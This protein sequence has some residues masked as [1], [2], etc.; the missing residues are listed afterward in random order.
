MTQRS[1]TRMRYT[2]LVLLLIGV[3]ELIAEYQS[4]EPVALHYTI[5]TIVLI[6][7]FAVAL[8]RLRDVTP[9]SN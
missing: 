8:Y 1:L 5:A 7:I 6:V 9:K 4:K 2:Y 3:A